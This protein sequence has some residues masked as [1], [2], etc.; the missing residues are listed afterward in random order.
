MLKAAKDIAAKTGVPAP[1]HSNDRS[2]QGDAWAKS[3]GEKLP[4]RLKFN[5]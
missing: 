4:E 3:T 1:V 2:D 5:R